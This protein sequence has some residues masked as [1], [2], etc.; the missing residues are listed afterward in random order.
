MSLLLDLKAQIEETENRVTDLMA[1][2]KVDEA[3]EATGELAAYRR[4]YH[5]EAKRVD[6]E[7]AKL[8]AQLADSG[9]DF[10]ARQS[11]GVLV[12]GNEAEFTGIQNRIGQMTKVEN[13]SGDTVL[14]I[15]GA[16][17]LEVPTQ[18]DKNLPG[19]VDKPMGYFDTLPKYTTDG[20]E[21]YFTQGTLVN[22]A[23]THTLGERKAQSE[24]SWD[25]V[26]VHPETIAHWIPVHKQMANR[27]ASLVSTIN[28]SLLL[29]LKWKKGAKCLHGS[30]NN[31]IVGATNFTGIQTWTFN[32][33]DNIVDNLADMAMRSALGSGIAPNYCVL[34][35][36]AI[37]AIAKT[38]DKNGQYLFPNFKNGD[39]IPGT[40]MTAVEDVNM[41]VTTTTK[42]D[43]GKDVT[44]TTESALVYNNGVAAYKSLD[45]DAV[46][47]G[48][49]N[50]QFV[51]NAF[52]LLAECAGLHRIDIPASYVYCADLG[53]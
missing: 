10:D 16:N 9:K 4:M 32:E 43:Q 52:T 8:I 44:T 36:N 13:A 39:T 22:N 17:V 45:N 41:S 47:A 1:D 6:E 33:S 42:D 49:V 30:N 48:F 23:D 20:P 21:R 7:N 31:G 28:Q 15:T 24:I 37:R 53:L 50:D 40:N 29:G 12:L 35:P 3:R 46:T 51:R 34:S 5:D 14:G 19:V 2:N 11:L 25:E 38:K 18:V 27:Y 26:T